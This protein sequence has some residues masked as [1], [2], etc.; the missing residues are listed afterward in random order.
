MYFSIEYESSLA[1]EM[2]SAWTNFGVSGRPYI[3]SVIT[4]DWIKFST[5]SS[6]MLLNN[7]PRTQNKFFETY[8][9]G[10]CLFWET[11]DETIK[12]DFCQNG[13]T[14]TG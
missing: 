9:N 14:A 6:V 5:D 13:H 1:Y 8:N 10:A 4:Q 2:I 12:F 11:V 7:E 3:D